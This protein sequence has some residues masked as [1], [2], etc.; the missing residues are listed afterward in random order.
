MRPDASEA[1]LLSRWSPESR[2]KLIGLLARRPW[3][4]DA[5][6]APYAVF[7]ADNTLWNGDVGETAL[8]ALAR[9]LAIPEG[10]AGLLPAELPVAARAGRPA[11]R[12]FPAARFREAWGALRAAWEALAPRRPFEELRPE[13]LDLGGQL[14]GQR[15]LVDAWRLLQ[16]T[17]VA[18]HDLLDERVGR[19][20]LD[21]GEARDLDGLLP[22]W[23]AAFFAREGGLGTVRTAPDAAG[24]WR[25]L[26]PRLRDVGAEGVTL[27]RAGLAGCYTQIAVWVAWGR[28]PDELFALGE[29]LATM[30]PPRRYPTIYLIDRHDRPVPAPLP[31]ELPLLEGPL[32]EELFVGSGEMSLGVE[33][34]PAIAELLALLEAGGITP[35]VVS[36]SQRDIVAGAARQLYGIPPERATG[37]LHALDG[38]AYGPELLEPVPYGLGKVYTARAGW[39]FGEARPALCAGDANT[40]LELMAWSGDT[41]VFLDRGARPLMDL[42]RHLAREAADRVV[43]E[44]PFERV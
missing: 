19:V 33:P 16:G 44:R 7:D 20:A 18:T 3:E 34:R 43:V 30:G 8:L 13:D 1:S 23:S 17:L 31:L 29:R 22:P 24:G 41:T 36:A 35:L 25:L 38:Q 10:L 39:P 40:D 37:M 12:F 26:G 2:A 15:R 14:S 42:A 11:G 9:E 28:R 32:G 27:A 5:R 6:V 4:Q 21:P